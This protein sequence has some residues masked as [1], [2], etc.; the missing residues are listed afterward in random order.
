MQ[1]ILNSSYGVTPT[2][3]WAFSHF[4]GL[5]CEARQ[6]DVLQLFRDL[7]AA[8]SPSPGICLETKDVFPKSGIRPLKRRWGGCQS[9]GPM[10]V[11]PGK[12]RHQ[13]PKTGNMLQVSQMLDLRILD[14][15]LRQ[16]SN[17]FLFLLACV[18][19]SK[20]IYFDWV[21]QLWAVARG[22]SGCSQQLSHLVQ[23]I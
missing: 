17:L 19:L 18:T 8:I 5:D 4:L 21:S 1:C 12:R 7:L 15:G 6:M 13:R 16:Q 2:G 3:T 22:A 20:V 11:F 23:R 14:T 9:Q 10:L